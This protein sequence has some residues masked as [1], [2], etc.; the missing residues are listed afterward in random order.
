MRQTLLLR[1]FLLGNNKIELLNKY[2]VYQE[3]GVS[4]YW[5]VSLADKTMLIYTLVDGKFHAS[6]LFSCSETVH[7]AVLSGFELRLE[8]VFED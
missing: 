3:F 2:N 4:E 7:S 8:K 1:F 5:V 6:K